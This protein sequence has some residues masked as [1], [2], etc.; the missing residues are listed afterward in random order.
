MKTERQKHQ[1]ALK[2]LERRRH[3]VMTDTHQA[4]EVRVLTPR[5]SPAVYRSEISFRSK[6][7]TN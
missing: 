7:V 4:K 1:T 5:T 2:L 3:E 6:K